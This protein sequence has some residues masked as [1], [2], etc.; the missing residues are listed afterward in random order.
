MTDN[1]AAG[2]TEPRM[3]PDVPGDLVVAAH[4]AW[5]KKPVQ[6]WGVEGGVDGLDDVLRHILAAVI[7]AIRAQVADEID[8]EANDYDPDHDITADPQQD[9]PGAAGNTYWRAMCRTEGL[10]TAA[11]IARGD[12]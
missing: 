10:R 2:R 7:P 1:P 9:I 11:K 5:D 8:T 6:Y 3:R 12:Q 4:N